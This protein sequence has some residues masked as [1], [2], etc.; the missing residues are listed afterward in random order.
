M[1]SVKE[2]L[3]ASNVISIVQLIVKSVFTEFANNAK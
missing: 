3:D 2:L 1:R